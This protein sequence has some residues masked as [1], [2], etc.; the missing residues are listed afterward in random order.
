MHV[1]RY[2]SNNMRHLANAAMYFPFAA[3]HWTNTW[4]HFPFAALQ[5]PN[6]GVKQTECPVYEPKERRQGGLK[7]MIPTKESSSL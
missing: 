4:L 5:L 3:L 7:A 1:L 6:Y 2:R